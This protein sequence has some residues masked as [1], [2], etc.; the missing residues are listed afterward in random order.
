MSDPHPRAVDEHPNDIESIAV[1][2]I[3]E[4]VDPDVRRSDELAPLSP[5]DCLH[6]VT[7]LAA[8][9]R[10]HLHEHYHAASSRH[11]VEIAMPITKPS[12]EECPAQLLEPTGRVRFTGESQCLCRHGANLGMAR[13]ECRRKTPRAGAKSRRRSRPRFVRRVR[14]VRLTGPWFPFVSAPCPPYRPVVSVRVRAVSARW[15]PLSPSSISTPTPATGTCSLSTTPSLF[16]THNF[17]SLLPNVSDT[18]QAS[19]APSGTA[20]RCSPTV[21]STT[22]TTPLSCLSTAVSLADADQFAP[23]DDA[24]INP[25]TK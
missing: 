24:A 13:A 3:A 4:P 20:R 9:P 23:N 11:E 10:L 15:T 1:R 6:R 2:G 12:L 18:T 19:N 5:I 17:S 7:E 14:R 22:G 25:S 21:R 16:R 8:P